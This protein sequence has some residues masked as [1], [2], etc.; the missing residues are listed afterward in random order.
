MVSVILFNMDR[1]VIRLKRETSKS[2]YSSDNNGLVGYLM[3]IYVEN[4]HNIDPHIFVMQR[5]IGGKYSQ[6]SLDTF[7]S[8]ASVGELEFLSINEPNELYSNF[9]RTNQIELMFETPQE[10]EKAWESISSEVRSLVE[11]NDL[12]INTSPD[13]IASYPLDAFLRYFG[14]SALDTPT[15]AMINTLG[16]DSGYSLESSIQESIAL[17]QQEY[18]Y[19]VSTDLNV[20]PKIVVDGNTQ[21]LQTFNVSVTNKYGLTTTH[22]VFRTQNKLTAALHTVSVSKL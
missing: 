14:T 1:T 6:E 4:Y 10:L 17:T 3:K 21:T 8:I 20:S 2:L 22:K 13:V 19:F 9:Y 11:A 7:Y 5:D 18:Y 12:S 15:E 16:S